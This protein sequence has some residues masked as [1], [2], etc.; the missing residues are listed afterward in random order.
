LYD[1]SQPEGWYSTPNEV[2]EGIVEC[3]SR[4]AFLRMS[5]D[6]YQ[7]GVHL[8]H[9]ITPLPPI[10]NFSTVIGLSIVLSSCAATPPNSLRRAMALSGRLHS[11][12][13][14]LTPDS[15]PV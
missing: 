10:E 7:F 8:S 12:P 5:I 3:F 15:Q 14:S 11:P 1:G 2:A 6:D 13:K 9:K 4:E